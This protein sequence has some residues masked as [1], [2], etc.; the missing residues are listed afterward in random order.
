MTTYIVTGVRKVL[1]DDFSHRHI[2]GV[3]TS[4]RVHY[5]VS[6]VVESINAGNTWR[7]KADGRE[8]TIQVV[9]ECPQ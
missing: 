2:E 7:T 1:S 4:D 9:S 5:S 6:D 8:E 3:C